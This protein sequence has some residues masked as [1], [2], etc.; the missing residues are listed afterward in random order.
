MDI[1]IDFSGI[2][3]FFNLPP[4]IALVN[5]FFWFGLPSFVIVLFIGA[6][7]I[8]LDNKQGKWKGGIKF[9]LLAIDI[10]RSNEQS[11]KAVENMFSYLGGAHG[12][13]NLI[14]E[15]IEGQFQLTFSYEI[16]SINGYTQFLIHTPEKFRNLIETSVYSQYPDAEIT[17]VD[18]YTEGMPTKYPDD[19]WDVWGTE[20][21]YANNETYPIKT[22]K[23]FEHQMGPTEMQYKD[24]LSA[25][26]DLCGSLRDG[27]QIWYQIIVKPIGFNE[28]DVSEPE[29]AE[30]LNEKI[31]SK[32]HLGD[33][34]IDMLIGILHSFSEFI[35]K[36]W[37]DI[38]SETKE[39]EDASL[40]MIELKPIQKNKIEAISEKA[41]QANFKVK[42][43]FVYMAKKEVM[44]KSKV[45]N[46]FVGFLKQFADVQL[47]NLKPDMKKTATSLSFAPKK[48]RLNTRKNKI[49][50][51]YIGRS[52][53]SGRNMQRMSIEELATLWNFP[54]GEYVKATGLQKVAAKKSQA[55]STLPIKDGKEDESTN[56]FNEIE[57]DL[58]SQEEKNNINKLTEL[59]TISEPNNSHQDLDANEKT[60]K[61]QKKS[62]ENLES[63]KN[64]T[65]SNLP[66]E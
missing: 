49:T 30:I 20:F 34:I 35:Y 17:E 28:M 11:P 18:D 7:Q 62:P 47:N 2:T 15:Y 5:I 26:M 56:N 45:V 33:L 60:P 31:K 24:P 39:E 19:T 14:E 54:Q 59:N 1:I 41:A 53:S 43:R 55:P 63:T 4:D 40:K 64:N 44:N 6:Y 23:H 66:F 10:P 65:P 37:S 13:Q 25:L 16:V 3:N 48:S 61:Y 22:Y 58:I 21:I 46:G 9:I 38:P 50:K 51:N 32:K 27:E 8:W 42:I 36:M 52:G 57:Q 12:T 29:I